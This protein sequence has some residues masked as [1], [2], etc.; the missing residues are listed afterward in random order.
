[1]AASVLAAAAAP[2]AWADDTGLRSFYTFDRQQLTDRSQVAVNVA[3]GNVVLSA[4]DVRIAGTGLSLPVRRHYNSRDPARRGIFGRG[5]TS[6]AGADNTLVQE[7][8]GS[9]VWRG[10]SGEE[11][12]FVPQSGGGFSQ[13]P[14]LNGTLRES[15]DGTA[16]ITMNR[17]GL[18]LEFTAGSPRRLDR[19]VDRNGNT[20]RYAYGAKGVSTITDTQGRALTFAYDA[21]GDL[22]TI[23]DVSG[24]QW[25]YSYGGDHYLTG[26]TDPEGKTTSFGYDGSGRINQINDPRGLVTRIGYDGSGRALSVT[27]VVDGTATNDVTTAYAYAA[28]SAACSS[29]DHQTKTVVTDPRG[30]QTT[31][32]SDADWR[33]RQATN[34]LGHRSD[35]NYTPNGDMLD[36]SR[37]AGT[38]NAETTSLTYELSGSAPTFNLLGGTGGAGE[39]FALDYY[40]PSS[41]DPGQRYRPRRAEDAQGADTFFGYDS[42]GDLTDVKD[43]D[44]S[45]RNQATLAYNDNGTLRSATDGEGRATSFEYDAQ[46]NLTRVVPQLPLGPTSYTYDGLSRVKTVTDGRGQT[47]TLTYDKLDRVVRIDFGHSGFFVYTF[48]PDGNLLRR[49]DSAGNVSTYAYDALNRR[50]AERFPESKFNDYTYTKSSQLKTITDGSGTASYDYDAIDRVTTIVAPNTSGGTD[51]VSYRYDDSGTPRTRSQDLPGGVTQRVDRDKSGKITKVVSTGSAG[52]V[53]RSRSYRYDESASAGNK[54]RALI[55]SVT[56]EAGRTTSYTYSDEIDGVGRLLKARTVDAAGTLVEEFAYSYERPATAPARCAP[57]RRARPRPRTPTTPPTRS[58]GATAARR[59][60]AAAR[61]RP[62]RPS[63]PTTPRATRPPAP[64][65]PLTTPSV[66]STP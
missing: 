3:N 63:S 48:D 49:E 9:R 47:R 26:Y 33:V 58:A 50:T 20:L 46:G 56:D 42:R 11:F 16:T 57:P 29:A 13:P 27:R 36:F 35:T 37:F 15:S 2:A 18:R 14:G 41:T 62:G 28:P 34:A 4:F 61:R 65:P 1:V 39:T 44:T 60:T 25:S 51:A 45:V 64:R 66:A 12:R 54:Q 59:A 52:Q 40:A 32:C 53:L 24:R 55:Q 17:S 38:A 8:D 7:S 6:S 30:Q 10:G 5:W 19:I 31:Y 43:S 21:A 22:R 23:T